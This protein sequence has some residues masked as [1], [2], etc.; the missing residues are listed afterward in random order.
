MNLSSFTCSCLELCAV[1]YLCKIPGGARHPSLGLRVRGGGVRGLLRSLRTSQQQEVAEPQAWAEPYRAS[2][3]PWWAVGPLCP[4]RWG[5]CPPGRLICCPVPPAPLHPQCW[6]TA[7]RLPRLFPACLFSH[8]SLYYPTF[9]YLCPLLKADLF[10]L[11]SLS[12]PCPS[13]HLLANLFRLF[14]A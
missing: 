6:H 5:Q 10:I 4:C 7:A 1:T 14:S 11:E 13:L 12:F 9:S 2:R 8:R 3:S